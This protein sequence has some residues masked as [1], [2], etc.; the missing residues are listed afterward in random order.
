GRPNVA[1]TVP[2]NLPENIEML[3]SIGEVV[4]FVSSCYLLM[5][6]EIYWRGNQLLRSLPK[7]YRDALPFDQLDGNGR[8]RSD[9]TE[10]P[11]DLFM[12]K[13]GFPRRD[14]TY[15][16]VEMLQYF[17]SF[18]PKKVLKFFAGT[19]EPHTKLMYRPLKLFGNS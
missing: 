2:F 14:P 11:D 3:A 18:L 10:L 6:R 19:P 17:I 13:H 9:K 15:R 5:S 1:Y 16:N 4:R 8:R 7:K 12:K